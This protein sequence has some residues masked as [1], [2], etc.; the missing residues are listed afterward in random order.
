MNMFE[1][2]TLIETPKRARTLDHDA[3]EEPAKKLRQMEE[4][5]NKVKLISFENTMKQIKTE[6][7][8]KLKIT[9]DELKPY[10]AILTAPLDEEKKPSILVGQLD[11]Q[12]LKEFC[13][14]SGFVIMRDFKS[15]EREEMI[16]TAKTMGEILE[17][18]DFGNQT[19]PNSIRCDS[20]YQG[21]KGC[22]IIYYGT[23]S[24]SVPL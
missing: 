12:L 10:G 7:E 13:W 2:S 15:L 5:S 23:R 3:D 18:P 9:V 8:E 20:R 14:K 1:P 24:S 21:R 19:S 4:N 11:P 16:K 6:W 22:Q 17:W